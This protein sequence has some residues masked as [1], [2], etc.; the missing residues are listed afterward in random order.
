MRII[1]QM[2][3][4]ITLAS[5]LLWLAICLLWGYLRSLKIRSSC[6]MESPYGRLKNLICLRTSYMINCLFSLK[7]MRGSISAALH[8]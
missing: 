3:V 2:L 7:A 8:F 4:G 6:T 5:N 1:L